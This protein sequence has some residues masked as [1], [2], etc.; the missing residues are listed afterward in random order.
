MLYRYRP[1]VDMSLI[2]Y[3]GGKFHPL[4]L[5]TAD[6]RIEEVHGLGVIPF[7]GPP[8]SRDHLRQ[9]TIEFF[10]IPEAFQT[11]RARVGVNPLFRDALG[12]AVFRVIGDGRELFRSP[13]IEATGLPVEV[14]VLLGKTR[15][16]TLAMHYA[17]NPTYEDFE[18]LHCDWALH[19]VWAEPRLESK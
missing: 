11:F 17:T 3:S 10:L 19:G 12:A 7:L 2:P 16:L 5:S 13:E 14:D 18:R 15:W 6:G 1:M 8:F 4:A 9:A